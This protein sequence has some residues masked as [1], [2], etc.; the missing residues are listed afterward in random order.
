VERAVKNR[1]RWAKYGLL[2]NLHKLV[3]EIAQ[4]FDFSIVIQFQTHP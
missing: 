1:E 2:S 3:G 4:V